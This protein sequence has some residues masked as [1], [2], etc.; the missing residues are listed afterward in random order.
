MGVGARQ[1]GGGARRG[2]GNRSW[3][4]GGGGG[5][6]RARRLGAAEGSAGR[7]AG[8]RAERGRR[9]VLRSTF[10]SRLYPAAE[11]ERKKKREPAEGKRGLCR[12]CVCQPFPGL[13]AVLGRQPVMSRAG[14]V[15]AGVRIPSSPAAW[16]ASLEAL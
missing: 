13:G 4:A 2:A 7:R 10:S 6:G 1:G 5:G 15:G 9:G 8:G 14:L 11:R 12:A 16:R 3:C